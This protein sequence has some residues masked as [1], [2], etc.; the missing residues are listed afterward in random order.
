[1]LG[2][3][4]STSLSSEMQARFL[5]VATQHRW[6]GETSC[7]FRQVF[8]PARLWRP[9]KAPDECGSGTRR[10][11]IIA[12][13]RSSDYLQAVVTGD[14]LS[15]NKHK[16]ST[17]F[18]RVRGQSWCS[19]LITGGGASAPLNAI[20]ATSP[21][22]GVQ[23]PHDPVLRRV[24]HTVDSQDGSQARRGLGAGASGSF[25]QGNDYPCDSNAAAFEGV[26]HYVFL[27]LYSIPYDEQQM[28]RSGIEYKS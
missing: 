1:M 19:G 17:V 15:P 4:T 10:C 20:W 22:C 12:V 7:P 26:K 8:P 23:K 14:D 28:L 24:L 27:M 6:L 16:R 21:P 2:R 13:C 3:R 11:W 18:H 5:S 25:L 9:D